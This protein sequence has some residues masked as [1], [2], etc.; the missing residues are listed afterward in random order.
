MNG[1]LHVV[2]GMWELIQDYGTQL[3]SRTA[4][5]RARSVVHARIQ[6]GVGWCWGQDAFLHTGLW[7]NDGNVQDQNW[8]ER[9]RY[10]ARR[11]R[12]NVWVPVYWRRAISCTIGEKTRID[13]RFEEISNHLCGQHTDSTLAW[14]EIICTV[15]WNLDLWWHKRISF[16]NVDFMVILLSP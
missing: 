3:W 16:V 15:S 9:P 12:E 5:I 4:Y 8:S 14:R 2:R 1:G 13:V 7:R 6:G 10:L 11:G